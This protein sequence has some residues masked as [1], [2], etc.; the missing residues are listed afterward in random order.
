MYLD[1]RREVMTSNTVD[2]HALPCYQSLIWQVHL[3]RSQA[4]HRGLVKI[5]TSISSGPGSPKMTLGQGNIYRSSFAG[6]Y[7]LVW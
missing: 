1:V 7:L 4:V 6:R 5:Y 2:A 3:Y